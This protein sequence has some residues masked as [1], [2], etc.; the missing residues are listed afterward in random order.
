MTENVMN[1]LFGDIH[2]LTIKGKGDLSSRQAEIQLPIGLAKVVGGK[3]MFFGGGMALY[4]GAPHT[5]IE[6]C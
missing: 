5:L 2:K 6:D 4:V 3:S 1:I